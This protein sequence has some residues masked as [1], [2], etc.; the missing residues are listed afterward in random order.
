VGEMVELLELTQPQIQ[1]L[2]N[3]HGIEDWDNGHVANL[4]ELVEGHP[5]LIR[6]ALYEVARG[7]TDLQTILTTAACTNGLYREHLERYF[8]Y[9][10]RKPELKQIMKDVVRE[11]RPLPIYS[12][13]LP[14]LND[15]GLIKINGDL[16]EPTN[17]LYKS[18]FLKRL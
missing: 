11:N 17:Q 9:L 15:S 18:Y 16:V 6:L 4:M 8:R 2:V 3:L 7:R 14:Q 10:E 5:F 1:N 12:I 13:L